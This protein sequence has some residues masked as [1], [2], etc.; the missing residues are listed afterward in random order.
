MA[1]HNEE[2][3]R[4]ETWKR[5]CRL[6]CVVFVRKSPSCLMSFWTHDKCLLVFISHLPLW[7]QAKHT[8]SKTF[9]ILWLAICRPLF[10]LVF[11]F[12]LLARAARTCCH[13]HIA[14]KNL[15]HEESRVNWTAERSW[16]LTK[17]GHGTI[18]LCPNVV[19]ASKGWV[20]IVHFSIYSTLR[21]RCR[22]ESHF[23]NPWS[24]SSNK[25][26]CSKNFPAYK[27]STTNLGIADTLSGES[28]GEVRSS[29][30]GSVMK[31]SFP[32]HDVFMINNRCLKSSFRFIL[33]RSN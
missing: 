26:G 18:V 17:C 12:E 11:W 10:A 31:K 22:R 5:A 2:D 23:K 4:M 1:L 6:S 3:W 14:A 30:K 16:M 7:I 29:H 20:L 32:C 28:T 9:Y 33:F 19:E 25:P 15:Y 21:C 13:C 8:I 27:Q 24:H